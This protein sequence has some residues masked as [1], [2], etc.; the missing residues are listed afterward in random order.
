MQSLESRERPISNQRNTRSNL[1]E[2][3]CNLS[4]QKDR[5]G[6]Y[7]GYVSTY[8]YTHCS[9]VSTYVRDTEVVRA[10]SL[11]LLKTRFAIVMNFVSLR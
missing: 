6:V 2:Q 1:E 10:C 4:D 7:N 9:I 8:V 3:N 5:K 11:G